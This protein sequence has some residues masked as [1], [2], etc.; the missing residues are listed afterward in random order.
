MIKLNWGFFFVWFFNFMFVIRG[1]Q[2][3]GVLFEELNGD[4][5]FI[6]FFCVGVPRGRGFV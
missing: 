3:V 2:G 4:Y 5:F 1:F 6:V